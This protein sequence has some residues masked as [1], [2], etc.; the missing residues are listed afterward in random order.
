MGV[1][2]RKISLQYTERTTSCRPHHSDGLHV[3]PECSQ[4]VLFPVHNAFYLGAYQ[5]A[6]NEGG[7]LLGLSEKDAVDRD[8]FVYRSYIALGSHQVISL[9]C[10]AAPESVLVVLLSSAICR[11][12][13]TS[14]EQ[15]ERRRAPRS[16]SHSSSLNL[17]H[18]SS[19]ARAVRGVGQ[20]ADVAPGREAHGA[21]HG[22][23]GVEGAGLPPSFLLCFAEADASPL[24]WRE[25]GFLENLLMCAIH[26]ALAR[27]RPQK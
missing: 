13:R 4:D 3:P 15:A 18:F 5:N 24:V 23:P 7:D 11:S 1:R 2:T 19:A 26:G 6:I 10:G 9:C 17:Y 21:V 8:C 20:C 14:C 22:E 27:A 12:Q 16:L 25:G